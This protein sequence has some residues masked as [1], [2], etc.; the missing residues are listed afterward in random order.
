MAKPTI[1]AR[2]KA[3]RSELGLSQVKVAELLGVNT[4]TVSNWETDNTE[5]TPGIMGAI[6]KKLFGKVAARRA[7]VAAPAAPAPKTR[8]LKS[9]SGVNAQTE[10]MIDFLRVKSDKKVL[11]NVIKMLQ[12]ARS[13]SMSL[14]DIITVL[15]A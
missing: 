14:D 6:E 9:H 15:Y 11:E 10:M 7:D 13:S 5:P 2:I 12:S 8:K 3:A 1:G 4:S